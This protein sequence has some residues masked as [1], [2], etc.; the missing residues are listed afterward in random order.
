MA[1]IDIRRK[2]DLPLKEARKA[3]DKVARQ[4]GTEFDVEC[5]WEGNILAFTRSGV[6]GHIALEK[7][8]V[9][10]YAELGLVMGMMKGLIESEINR[11]L[12]EQIG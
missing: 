10:V 9:H 6:D 2:H 4:L 7:G 1:R 11:H 8:Q 3:V 12:D 5:T